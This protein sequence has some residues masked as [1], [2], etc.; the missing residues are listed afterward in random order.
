MNLRSP[1]VLPEKVGWR[2]HLIGASL[3]SAYV[4]WLLA[5]ARSLGFAR[6]EGFYFRAAATYWRWFDALFTRPSDALKQGFIDSIWA[7]NHE[8]PP[9]MKVLF[10]FSWKFLHEKWHIFTDASTAFRFPGMVMMGV[11]LWVTYL[12][13]ARAYSRRAG[14]IA[15]ALLALMPRVFYNAHL[16]CFDV[17]DRRDV[18][19]V[20]LRLLADAGRG[21]MAVGDRNGRGLRAHARDEGKCLVLAGGDRAARHRRE[22]APA[23]PGL[24]QR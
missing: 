23:A 15:A 18:D 20:H 11:A 8:H 14:A 5:T 7:E 16:A 12:F 21:G 17:P 24:A 1:F 19:V 10:A 3:G 22:L 4:A 9:L 2:D 6:D 13:G